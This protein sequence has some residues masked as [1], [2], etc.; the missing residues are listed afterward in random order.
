MK[1]HGK[2]ASVVNRQYSIIYNTYGSLR[3]LSYL[4]RKCPTCKKL[5]PPKLQ[6]PMGPIIRESLGTADS[7]TPWSHVAT[8]YWGPI[9]LRNKRG[10]QTYQ[11]W[12]V[13]MLDYFSRAAECYL[14]SN[15]STEGFR[16]V[17][18]Q[19]GSRKGF[20][21]K[22]FMDAGTQ[23][24]KFAEAVGSR[25]KEI[26]KGQLKYDCKPPVDI[27]DKDVKDLDEAFDLPLQEKAARFGKL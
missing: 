3:Y 16:N 22:L 4:K 11:A 10:P 25:K 21:K 12:G 27:D 2:S 18:L 14:V 8:D 15:Y 20:P 7:Q 26:I 23:L 6:T 13:V 1:N 9:T 19:H 5:S 24:Q 17:I